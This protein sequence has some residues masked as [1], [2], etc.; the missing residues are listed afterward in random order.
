M[1]RAAARWNRALGVVLA[2]PLLAPVSQAQ[3]LA[4]FLTDGTRMA[5]SEYEVETERV[6]YF[7]AARGQW[8]EVPRDIV[9]W[10]RTERHNAREAKAFRQRQDQER[11][12]RAAERRARTELHSVPLD[13]GVYYLRGEERLPLEQ[14]TLMV[15]KSKKRTVLNVIAPVPVMPGKRTMAVEGL[16]AETVTSGEKPAFYLRLDRFSRFGIA[17]V[18]LEEGRNRRV[19]QRIFT[20]P[21]S[22]DEFEDQDEIEV[23]RQQLAPLVYK[24]W[25]TDPLPA[26]E[27]AVIAYTPGEDDLRAWDFSH[28]P[29]AGA[30]EQ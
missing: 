23:F 4:L 19:V 9:D 24:I 27:Y 21:K 20:V 16:A 11:R 8:E 6:R 14:V 25:P 15:G 22:E 18:G 7:S 12:E 29:A 30:R 5:V 28:R 2:L 3:Q 10:E 1:L 17:R 26:G 13:D